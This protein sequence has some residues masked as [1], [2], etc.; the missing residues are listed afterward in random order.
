MGLK[1]RVR[2]IIPDRVLGHLSDRF[3]VTGDIAV[4]SLSP[5]LYEYKEIIAHAVITHRR[6]IRTVLNKVSRITGCNRTASYDIIAGQDTVT[7]HREYGFVYN[8]DV[9]S[10]FLT[11]GSQVSASVSL[12]RSGLA[13]ESSCHFVVSGPS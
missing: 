13:N 2:G 11:P 6:T 3:D 4:L 10:V 1:D 5:E 12:T 8:L 7:V 9:A